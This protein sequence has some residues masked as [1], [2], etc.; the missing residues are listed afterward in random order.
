MKNNDTHEDFKDFQ[1]GGPDLPSQNIRDRINSRVHRLL[2]PP[3]GI[4]FS[5]LF[6]IQGIIGFL[7]MSFCPQ[8]ELSLTNRYEL[9]HFFHR[10]FG[11]EIC[12]AMCGGIFIGCG[13]FCAA[14]LL[15]D[16]KYKK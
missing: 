6:M 9:F 5:K 15:K 3:H 10:N 11:A 12:M 7:S 2:D 16:P 14:L 8:F 1:G 4:V 13:A